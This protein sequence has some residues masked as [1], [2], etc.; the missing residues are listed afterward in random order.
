[1]ARFRASAISRCSA[2]GIQHAH[3]VE[4]RNAGRRNLN[5][6][7]VM[8]ALQEQN[9]QVAAGRIGQQPAP[10]GNDIQL[11][12]ST[13]GRLL[14]ADEFAEII[15]KIGDKRQI[16][17][18]G[19]IARI[20]LGAKNYDTSSYLDGNE[21]LGLAI[22]QRPGTNALDT[23]AQIK[24]LMKELKAKKFPRGVGYDIVYDTTVFVEESVEGVFHTLIEAFV[25]VFIVVLLF[26]QDWHATILPMIDV[27]VSLIGTFA[28][29]A[30]FG[31]SLNNLTLF[32]LVLAIGIVVDDAIVVVENVERWLSKGYDAREATLKAM[33]EVTGPVIAITLVLFSVF[34]PTAF[35][36]G[37]NGQF[38]R[39]FALTIAASTG[40]SA[41]N[42]LTMTPSRTAQI[43][44]NR[45]A[46][47][48]GHHGE[49]LPW[50]GIGGLLGLLVI[51]LLG[52]AVAPLVGLGIDEHGK[53]VGD[54]WKIWGLRIGIMAVAVPLGLL[55]KYPV[56]LVL[57]YLFTAFNKVFD[58]VTNAYGRI[59]AGLLRISV[60]MLIVYVG[61]LV[62]TWMG[63]QRIPTG[64]I[65]QQDKGYLIVSVSLPD[66]TGLERTEAV[67][68]KVSEIALKDDA[69]AHT[70][71]IPGLS[72]ITGTIS[73]TQARCSC[74]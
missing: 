30:L 60:V 19:D 70:I 41:M 52:R 8:H 27:P 62:M 44:K 18:L 11:S 4:S 21:S 47:A 29:M 28:V 38:Y 58:F 46:G 5:V 14:T 6:T 66:G 2:R 35:I 56:N 13:Q 40:I 68:R 32:G 33:A 24:T 43:F 61:L 63:F 25:L 57:G 7:D 1:M 15:V 17:R 49:A 45:K 36:A 9:V 31:F 55:L 23:A 12:I 26:L 71:T 73:R 51:V 65:P 34:I 48:H 42:A 10:V 3:L 37:I 64:F 22:F 69:V 50:W 20:E 59:V 39:Q 54:A 72:L 67:M 16:V 53:L 74:R